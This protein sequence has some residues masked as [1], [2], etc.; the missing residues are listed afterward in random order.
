MAGQDQNPDR[1]LLSLVLADAYSRGAGGDGLRIARGAGKDGPAYYLAAPDGRAAT[2][3]S[4]A[5]DA[6]LAAIVGMARQV[7]ELDKMEGMN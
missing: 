1:V 7:I 3:H 4:V 2:P 6:L 5:R